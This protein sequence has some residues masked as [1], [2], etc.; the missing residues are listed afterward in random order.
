MEAYED[1][2]F[3]QHYILRHHPQMTMHSRAAQFA[4]FAALTG[5]DE[6]IEKTARLTSSRH[7]LTEDEQAALNQALVYLAEHEAERPA[8]DVI[9]F[10]PDA[11]KDGG[12]YRMYSGNLRFFDTAEGLL[13][14][15]DRSSLAVRD[16]CAMRLHP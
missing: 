8:V 14:F 5:F 12:A 9:Y 4:P 13:H 15:T 7:E 3:C 10:Q 16:I 1:I 6:E 2:L 11:Q